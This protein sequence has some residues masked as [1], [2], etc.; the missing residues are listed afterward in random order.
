M[1]DRIF[2]FWEPKS[3]LT[4]Y[5]QLCKETWEVNLPDYEI[6]VLDYSNL[7]EYL[8]AD[9]FDLDLLRRI[10]L[11]TQKDAIMVA[12]L[13]QHG[14]VFM[15][16]DTIAIQDIRPLLDRL[17]GS[18]VVMFHKH[19]AVVAARPNARLL[20][21]CQ[22]GIEAKMKAL[23]TS[24]EPTLN[25]AWDYLGNSE[26]ANAKRAMVDESRL[27]RL[28]SR[29]AEACNRP[30]QKWLRRT[31][32]ANLAAQLLD[33]AT[34]RVRGGSERLAFATKFRRDLMVLDRVQYGFIA[35]AHASTRGTDPQQAYLDFWFEDHLSP[36]DAFREEQMVIALHN[37]WTPDW[38]RALDR[39]EVLSHDCL[40]SRTL[41][42]VL[43]R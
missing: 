19:M 39:D 32:S 4:P 5:L 36:D 25:M 30:A 37:S 28:P 27:L 6:V 24:D 9:V 20:S 35:E 17:E 2:T 7:H 40:L 15:D 11:H 10:P 41:K 29:V 1:I 31:G 21:L 3:K 43:N 34:R 12:L 16:M 13:V 18:E 8:D 26:L 38:Y 14:G 23:K 33:R 22:D 42:S